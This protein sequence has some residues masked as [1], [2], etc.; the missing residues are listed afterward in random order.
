MAMAEGKATSGS[1]S[2]DSS[3]V[4]TDVA[5]SDTE[6]D[7]EATQ[8]GKGEQQPVMPPHKHGLCTPAS[9][10][11]AIAPGPAVAM[12]KRWH[13]L[14]TRKKAAEQLKA[15]YDWYYPLPSAQTG[16]PPSPRLAPASSSSMPS[17][18]STNPAQYH[19]AARRRRERRKKNQPAATVVHNAQKACRHGM[20]RLVE[21]MAKHVH[22]RLGQ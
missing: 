19:G 4:P 10:S 7:D 16:D 9:T 1:A 22:S 14:L 15:I 6:I 13:Y 18:S 2:P 5:G 8:A 12:A 17:S 3:Y 21:Q 20:T 11:D